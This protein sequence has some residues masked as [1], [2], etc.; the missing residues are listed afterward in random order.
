MSSHGLEQGHRIRFGSPMPEI[1]FCLVELPGRTPISTTCGVLSAIAHGCTLYNSGLRLALILLLQHEDH[2]PLIPGREAV[3][4]T[5][6][7]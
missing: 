2:R 7:Q 5:V 1:Y 3:Q 6:F 4:A